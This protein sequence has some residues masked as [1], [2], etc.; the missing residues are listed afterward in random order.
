MYF[1]QVYQSFW[2]IVKNSTEPF[3]IRAA[4]LSL[5]LGSNINSSE[6]YSILSYMNQTSF[7]PAI[8][9]LHNYF[10]T[11]VVSGK[12]DCNC[13]MLVFFLP[14]CLVLQ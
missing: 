5:L 14:N 8:Q 6:L 9:H 10:Y 13:T 7:D 3:E 1:L 12:T 4:A 11:A 2:P